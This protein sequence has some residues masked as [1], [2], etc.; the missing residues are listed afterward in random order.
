VVWWATT[1]VSCAW[2]NRGAVLNTGPPPPTGY[3]E[4]NENGGYSDGRLNDRTITVT[5]VGNRFTPFERARNF[6]LRR[7]ADLTLSLGFG[8]FYLQEDRDESVTWTDGRYGSTC[9]RNGNVTNCSGR[10]PDTN[11]EPVVRITAVMVKRGRGSRSGSQSGSLRRLPTRGCRTTVILVS[12]L[13]RSH[14]RDSR[15]PATRP[16]I[17]AS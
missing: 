12:G 5:F 4:R 15:R 1:L 16:R 11:T 17:A 8:A 13:F 10:G 3:H 9:F 6:A 14:S 2:T 7:A